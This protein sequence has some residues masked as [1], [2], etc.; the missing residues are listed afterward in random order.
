MT[1]E[2][3]LRE[4][5]VLRRFAAREGWWSQ[6]RCTGYSITTTRRVCAALILIGSAFVVAGTFFPYVLVV[7]T[8]PGGAQD[9]TRTAWQ[10]G[11]NLS[12]TPTGGPL[13]TIFAVIV[14][15]EEWNFV[16][17]T[18]RRTDLQQWFSVSSNAVITIVL[19]LLSWPAKWPAETGLRYQRGWGGQLSLWG[20]LFTLAVLVVQGALYRRARRASPNG[21]A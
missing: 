10:M 19:I 16:R 4:N 15:V 3:G 14:C 20:A 21:A 11:Q 2:S 7:V 17:V 12:I 1:G 13:I 18:R 9:V 6:P 8:L 5:L